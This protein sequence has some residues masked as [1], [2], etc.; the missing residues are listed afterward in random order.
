MLGFLVLAIIALIAIDLWK[1]HPYKRINSV[2]VYSYFGHW[3]SMKPEKRTRNRDYKSNITAAALGIAALPRGV[4]RAKTHEKLIRI[5]EN[6]KQTTIIR[7]RKLNRSIKLSELERAL[8]KTDDFSA[9]VT[10]Y[11][12]KFEVI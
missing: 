1:Y 4:Y 2:L 6:Y 9:N 12:I 11:Y 3:I 10:L 5:L 7:R 8:N